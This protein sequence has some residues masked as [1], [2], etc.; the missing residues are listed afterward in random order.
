MKRSLSWPHS[1]VLVALTVFGLT[2]AALAQTQPPIPSARLDELYAVLRAD[3]SRLK[4]IEA[5][6]KLGVVGTGDSVPALAALLEDPQLSHAAR[7]G[8][9]AIPDPRAATALRTAVPKLKGQLLVGVLNSL[10]A[11]RDKLAITVLEPLLRAA[12]AEIA[13]AAA[14]ALGRIASDPAATALLTTLPT[15]GLQTQK[16]IGKAC[17]IAA[18]QCQSDGRGEMAATLCRAIILTQLPEHIRLAATQGV[19]L[20]DTTI[21]A[22]LLSSLMARDEAG[23]RMA[24]TIAHEIP[25]KTTTEALRAQMERASLEQRVLLVTALGDRKDEVV[26]P[27]L[28]KATDSEH[29][30]LR[31]AATSALSHF[32]HKSVR[33]KLL[34]LACGPN[35]QIATAASKAIIRLDDPAMNAML[36]KGLKEA[37]TNTRTVLYDL[38]GHRHIA[39]GL[40]ALLQGA[41]ANELDERVAA[42][43]ALGNVLPANQLGVLTKRLVAKSSPEELDATRVALL[44]SCVRLGDAET[45]AKEIVSCLPKT[46]GAVQLQLYE[47]LGLVGGPTALTAVTNAAKNPD[48]NVQDTITRVLGQWMTPDAAPLLL[49]IA[50]TH[51]EE[52]YRIRALRGYIRILRQFDMPAR[53]RIEMCSKAMPLAKRPNERSLMLDALLRVPSRTALSLA[54]TQ[55]EASEVQH[56]ACEVALILSN[57]LA[58]QAPNAV[59]QAMQ[60]VIA[61]TSD[62]AFKGYAQQLITRAKQKKTHHGKD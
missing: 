33:E 35:A 19:L 40:N 36:L 5:C 30:T 58:E 7:I 9:E 21:K 46:T 25:G 4:K 17:L 22:D 50:K 44:A 45:C 55:L 13:S 26:L 39:E 20:S 51:A 61:S 57:Q 34:E 11:R 27:T 6:K 54:L 24:L 16:A 8:L 15:A 47:L 48:P 23:F 10:G 62:P 60:E 14:F 41:E 49:S 18:Q 43:K 53:Q 3:T 52:K 56:R 12:D 38:I 37:D 29:A 32:Q 28:L 42:L 2:A 1:T 59:M 31:I